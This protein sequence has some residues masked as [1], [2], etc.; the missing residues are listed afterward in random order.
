MD[1]GQRDSHPQSA[2]IGQ[3][4]QV[5]RSAIGYGERQLLTWSGWH[6]TCGVAEHVAPCLHGNF[7]IEQVCMCG[8]GNG[9]RYA[10]AFEQTAQHVTLRLVEGRIQHCLVERTDDGGQPSSAGRT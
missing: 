8:Q 5:F 3:G 1:G 2:A 4:R 10:A 9:V 6:L 7:E